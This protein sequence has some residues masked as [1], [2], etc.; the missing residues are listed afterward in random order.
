MDANSG[1]AAN[2]AFCFPM[3][4]EAFK[5][6]SHQR[7]HILLPRINAFEAQRQRMRKPQSKGT[8]RVYQAPLEG[9]R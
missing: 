6:S 2:A 9:F 5:V 7:E 1:N 4:V 3:E 8:I